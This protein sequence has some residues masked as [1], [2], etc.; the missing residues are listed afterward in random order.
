MRVEVWQL[1]NVSLLTAKENR[2]E[3]PTKQALAAPNC[4]VTAA[5]KC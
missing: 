4:G 3:D 2:S 5:Q 1:G